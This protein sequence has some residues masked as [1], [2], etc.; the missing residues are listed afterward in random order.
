MKTVQCPRFQGN[1]RVTVAANS[2]PDSATDTAT[3][4]SPRTQ[5]G[6]IPIRRPK[7]PAED[8]LPLL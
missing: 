5:R 2:G 3:G 6:H 7:R 8:A 1:P 4:K